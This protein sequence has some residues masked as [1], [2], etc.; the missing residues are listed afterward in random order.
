FKQL[1]IGIS[2]SL[3][4]PAMGTAGLDLCLVNGF[5][6]VPRPPPKMTATTEEFIAILLIIILLVF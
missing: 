1:E 2:T 6:R 4:F 5:R 3:Y